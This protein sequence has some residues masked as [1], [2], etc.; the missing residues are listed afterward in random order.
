[1]A[2]YM[3]GAGIPTQ[4]DLT[5]RG[6][7][8]FVSGNINQYAPQFRQIGGKYTEYADATRGYLFGE[9]RGPQVVELVDHIRRGNVP[10]VNYDLSPIAAPKDT[11]PKPKVAHPPSHVAQGMMR[12][13]FDVPK[14]DPTDTVV[15]NL[16]PI[17]MPKYKIIGAEM[18]PYGFVR[19]CN[20]ES[21]D[22]G[23]HISIIIVDGEWKVQNST[24]IHGVTFEKA[25]LGFFPQPQ[26]QQQTPAQIQQP[27]FS[28]PPATIPQLQLQPQVQQTIP[29]ATIPQATIPQ[30]PTQGGFG[31][32]PAPLVSVPLGAAP[33]MPK[34]LSPPGGF[35]T[36]QQSQMQQTNFGGVPPSQ[37][38][39]NVFPPAQPAQQSQYPVTPVQQSNFNTMTMSPGMGMGGPQMKPAKRFF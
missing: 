31:L 27:T 25:Q 14:P 29:Q 32:P 20:L 7:K 5:R 3:Q 38:P 17:G 24:K 12:A 21:L 13:T 8:F 22:N 35:P 15:I 2:Q 10:V 37:P 16:G 19:R 39:M 23:S 26:L 33:A 6:K 9:R 36:A 34:P 30:L 18:H 11:T 4:I 28:P 1:M